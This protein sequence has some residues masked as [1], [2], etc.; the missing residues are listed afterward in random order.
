MP[1]GRPKQEP[2][3]SPSEREQ[4]LLMAPSQSLPHVLVP[5]AEIVRMS[6]GDANSMAI[7]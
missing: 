3:L 7:A 4:L 1:R 2:A 5:R 6:A